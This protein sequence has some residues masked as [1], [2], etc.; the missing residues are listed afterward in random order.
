MTTGAFGLQDGMKVAPIRRPPM[1]IAG[2]VMRHRATVYLAVALLTLGG[3]WALFTLPAGI[4]PEVT[5]PRIVV[6]ARGG[7]FEAD[8]MTVAVTRPLEEGVSGVLGLQ[9][10]RARTVRGS[11]ELSL[12]F[13]PEDRHAVR[14]E[15]GAGQARV[16]PVFAS[17]RCRPLCR[18]ARSLGL[19]DAAV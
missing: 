19:S 16:A 11:A 1:K 14:P 10:I 7:T 5:Y 17:R 15:P 3:L 8:E 12:D 4:Y 18:T 9:R 13:R 6:L 2:S